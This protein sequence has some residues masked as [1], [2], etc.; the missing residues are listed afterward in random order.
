[1]IKISYVSDAES[2]GRASALFTDNKPLFKITVLLLNILAVFLSF[3]LVLKIIV[4]GVAFADIP[5]IIGCVAWLSLRKRLNCWIFT[6][7]VANSPIINKRIDITISLNGVV[8]SG[9]KLLSGKLSWQDISYSIEAQN[10]FILPYS[11]SKFLW[12]PFSGFERESNLNKFREI[13]Q[14]KKIKLKPYYKWR[15]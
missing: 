10:G 9:E 1:M 15:C 8:W 5:I 11:F 12:L 6:K 2:I 4:D 7:K 14:S 3:I 13:L